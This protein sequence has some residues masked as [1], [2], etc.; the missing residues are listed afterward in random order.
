MKFTNDS[1]EADGIL[2]DLWRLWSEKSGIDVTFKEA[3]WSQAQQMILNGQAD[4]H[5]GMFYSKERDEVFDFTSPLLTQ[6]YFV[7]LDRS[8]RGIS[9]LSE[10]SGFKI[11][12]PKG[13]ANRYTAEQLPNAILAEFESFV[14]LYEAAWRGEVRVLIS[15]FVN[16]YYYTQLNEE[17]HRFHRLPGPPFYS[18]AY[19]AIL[20]KGNQALHKLVD[21]GMATISVQERAA[22]EQ[23]WLEKA[24]TATED[25]VT[26]AFRQDSAPLQFLNHEGKA[27]GVLIDFWRLW[28]EKSGL[29]IRFIGGTNEETQMMVRD[30]RADLNAGLFESKKRAT[31]MAFSEPILSSPYHIFFR[32]ETEGIESVD[33]LKGH[34]IGVTQGSFHESY[35]R[36]HFPDINLVLFKGYQ[37]LFEAITND[38]IQLIVTQ[39]LYLNHY[40]QRH[41]LPNIFSQLDPP[42]Y[43]RSYKAGVAKGASGLLVQINQQLLAISPEERSNISHRWLGLEW[44]EKQQPVMKFTAKEKAW[45]KS[46]PVINVGV[47]PSWPPIEFFSGQGVY[48]G[49]SSEY[50]NYLSE[51]LAVEMIA[52]KDLTWTEVL[53][54]VKAKKIDLLPAVARTESKEKYLN[55]TKPYL[56]FPLVLFTRNDSAYINSL[57]D[58]KGK[59]L[60]VE[61]GYLAHELLQRD[62]PNLPLILVPDTEQALLRLAQGDGDAYIGNLMVASYVIGQRGYSNLKVAAP[63]EYTYNLS[64]GVRKDWPELIPILQQALD[65]LTTKQKTAIQQKWLAIKYDLS[66]NYTLLW[67]VIVVA[68][69]IMFFGT[70]WALQV[71][72]QREALAEKEA[73]LR[74]IFEASKSVSFIIASGEDEPK[75]IEFSPGAEAIFGY[76]REEAIGLPA[77]TFYRDKEVDSF[78]N[79]ARLLKE[80]QRTL[81][82]EI[83]LVHKDGR[84]F[85]VLYSLYPMF[86][87]S[88]DYLGGLSVAID[89]THRKEAEKALQKA[90]QKAEDASKFKSQFLANMS[91]EIR[92]P[93]NAIIGMSYLAMHSE[94]N[95]KQHDYISKIS[96]SA[97]SLL[98]I[99]NDILDFSKIEEGK[100]N[101]ET[102]SFKIDEVMESLANLVTMKAEEKGIEILFSR[103]PHLSSHLRGDPLRLGQVLTN[104]TQ[105]AI[106]FTESGEI[107]VS[108]RIIES[109]DKGVKIRFSVRDSGIGIDNEKLAD[110]F[111][112]FTQVDGSTT[113]KYGG[114]GLGLSISKQLVELMGGEI[115]V[116]SELGKGSTFSFTLNFEHSI[117][118]IEYKPL[119][120]KNL[121]NLSILVVDDNASARQVLQEMLESFTYR[122]T[123]VTSGQEALDNLEAGHHYDLV[124]MDWQMPEMD[125]IEASRR[126]KSSTL[127]ANIPT[128]IMVTAYGREEVMQQA[129]QVGVEGFL[130]K[131]VNP[132]LMFDAIARAFSSEKNITSNA[133]LMQQQRIKERLQGKVLLVEDH[134]INQQ[135]ARELLEGFGL[136]IGIASNGLEAVKAVFETDFD[137]VLMDIQMPEMDGFEATKRIREDGRFANLPIIAMT[138][139][140]LTG[141]REHCIEQGM[142]EH[143]SKP[144]APDELF[145]ML[146][147]WLK[148]DKR[149]KPHQPTE[150]LVEK[151]DNLLPDSLPGIDIQWGVTR[152][153]GNHT[154]F[155]KLLA[156]FYQRHHTDQT[157]ITKQLH[158]G[159]TDSARRS[160]HTLQG[161]AGNIGAKHFQ[162]EARNLESAILAGEIAPSDGLPES[163]TSAF[164]QLFESLSLF[165]EE[166]MQQH[167]KSSE[168]TELSSDE[169]INVLKSLSAMIKDGNPDALE[170]LKEIKAA[171]GAL[172]VNSLLKN[173]KSQVENY[174][175]D[176]ADSTLK[177]LFEIL[178]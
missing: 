39:P 149:E 25:I 120:N 64:I 108:V 70:L 115:G 123:L 73:R 95:P 106:K 118:C 122:V 171:K 20:A 72:R 151:G 35:M 12:I 84:H 51:M 55:F 61:I 62:Y 137:L 99:I 153:G 47:D 168:Q 103:D 150:K 22:I 42:L 143:L 87:N 112:A 110:L 166:T 159:D 24:H 50:I 14:P 157:D 113:R 98:S 102:T 133:L 107:L 170:P 138:A 52:T 162:K 154:L 74:A 124:L 31:F 36:E 176:M 152:V 37:E 83:E 26:I 147:K 130:V 116:E 173:L 88:G 92:T 15:P 75:I 7:F 30:G 101:I 54:Q 148:R 44:V 58:L 142:N 78:Q 155:K 63:T 97:H 121:Q 27:A 177:Q 23:K 81:S 126:I 8:I 129:D 18:K 77:V 160:A 135:V 111:N 67:R 125:G 2:I 65:N 3:S 80:E 21:A 86:S 43:T 117:K 100:L 19:Q 46:H 68:L 32:P 6:D 158:N 49:I 66:A 82:G 41:G 134:P 34:L 132:S 91:H 13:Y 60:I 1:G 96:S 178:E 17:Q 33:D 69:L 40:L 169:L 89:I 164:N 175:F 79:T 5:A 163:F 161:V 59:S 71:R 28:S 136:V 16:L 140:A 156:E 144:I 104:L 172:Q 29:P 10:L 53:E 145:K 141:D 4:I 109:D 128:I 105:N 167:D 174:D 45:L 9:K 165:V 90:K 146:N 48:Q 85:P 56:N 38:K 93:M 139:H 76:T 131:P 114:T 127:L 57:E 94:L 119:L 11:G